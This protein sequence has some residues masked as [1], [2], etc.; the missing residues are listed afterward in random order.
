MNTLAKTM[1]E[2]T[3]LRTQHDADSPIG[4]H[5]SNIMRLIQMPN[6]PAHLIKVQMAGLHRAMQAAQ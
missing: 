2:L 3:V 6:P 5:A 1:S 4:H